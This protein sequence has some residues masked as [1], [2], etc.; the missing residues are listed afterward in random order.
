MSFKSRIEKSKA[1]AGGKLLAVMIVSCGAVLG[2]CSDMYYDRRETISLGANDHIAA[3]RVEQMIDP[4]P[5]YVG[6]KN[7]AFNGERM[8]A[9]VERYRRHEVIRPIS[10]VTNNLNLTPPPITTEAVSIPQ[11]NAQGTPAAAV[12]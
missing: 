8:Q 11:N 4:W 7:L 9:G 12:K 10:P 6:N 5:R 3:N 2:G 1:N